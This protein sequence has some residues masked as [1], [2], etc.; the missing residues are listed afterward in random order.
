MLAVGGD[1]H[2]G[3]DDID[4]NVLNYCLAEFKRQT[5]LELEGAEKVIAMCRLRDACEENKKCLSSVENRTISRTDFYQ[6][7]DLNVVLTRNKFEELNEQLFQKTIDLVQKT[8]EDNNITTSQINDI[9]LVGGSTRIPKVQKML[10]QFFGGRPLNHSVNP[11]EAVA[12]GAAI[13]AALLNG[14]HAESFE[15]L[16]SSNTHQVEIT[17]EKGKLAK[18]IIE[19]IL[20]QVIF[21]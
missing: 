9:V 7:K 21:V 18:E 14:K 6:K 3:G 2:L 13:Q 16:G 5:G 12:I 11:D 10:S 17:E 1:N 8:L 4:T 20:Q 19:K 15:D